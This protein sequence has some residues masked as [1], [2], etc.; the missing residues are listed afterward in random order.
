M[1]NGDYTLDFE[2]LDI[3]LPGTV[4]S[5]LEVE[6]PNGWRVILSTD[7]RY[8][9]AN[10]ASRTNTLVFYFTH[11]SADQRYCYATEHNKLA[12]YVCKSL[13]GSRL[14]GSDGCNIGRCTIY[15]LP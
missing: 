5:A 10:N 9:Y 3:T 7:K 4:I 6:S 8:V 1:A 2:E 11:P 14:G 12:E 15:K 13:G